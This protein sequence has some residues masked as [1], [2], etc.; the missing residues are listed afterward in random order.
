LVNIGENRPSTIVYA[1]ESGLG[2]EGGL[3]YIDVT[4][5]AKGGGGGGKPR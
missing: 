2:D 5:S 3:A 4:L 1:G